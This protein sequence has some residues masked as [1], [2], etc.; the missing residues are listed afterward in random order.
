MGGIMVTEMQQWYMQS[1]LVGSVWWICDAKL[2]F[3]EKNM[4]L[5]LFFRIYY[6]GNDENT[7]II[8]GVGGH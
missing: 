3:F 7:N 4:F 8:V 5:N 6:F 1:L 2:Y